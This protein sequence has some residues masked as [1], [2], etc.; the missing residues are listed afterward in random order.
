MKTT[1]IEPSLLTL[2]RRASMRIA[3][4]NSQADAIN[5]FVNEQAQSL[6]VLPGDRLDLEA[7]VVVRA[8]ATDAP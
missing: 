7:G 6:S 2:M 8:E 5:D 3:I 1:P 4:L